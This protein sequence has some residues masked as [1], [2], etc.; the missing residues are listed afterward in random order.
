[1][2]SLYAL[3]GCLLIGAQDCICGTPLQQ[4]E[5]RCQGFDPL[6]TTIHYQLSDTLQP[7]WGK[8]CKKPAFTDVG[9]FSF[10]IVGPITDDGNQTTERCQRIPFPDT[11]T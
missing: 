10:T 6:H 4:I 11:Y 9:R 2:I 3:L 7:P 5:A 1:M 8:L